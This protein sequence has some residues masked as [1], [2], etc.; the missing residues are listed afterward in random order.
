MKN[1]LIFIMIFSTGILSGILLTKYLAPK[2][3]LLVLSKVPT[4][5]GLLQTSKIPEPLHSPAPRE[6]V[7]PLCQKIA[8]RGIEVDLTL[9]KL[10]MCQDGKAV[11]E[12]IISSGKKENETPTGEF[13]V[14]TKSSMLYS[15]LANS[16]LPLWVGFKDDYGFHEVPISSEGRRVGEDKIGEPDSLG[17]IR[18]KVGDAE[19][20]YKFAEIGTKIVIFGEAP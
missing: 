13:N 10:R 9:Q 6:K 20:V 1:A 2:I 8:K 17:C 4:L 7:Q 3:D 16:W 15:K 18:L 5:S 12:L 19:K 14:I 11:A